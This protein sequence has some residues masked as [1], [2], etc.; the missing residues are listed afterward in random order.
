MDEAG[1]VVNFTPIIVT[2]YEN[3]LI[4]GEEADF[5]R[6][7][8][9]GR[10]IREPVVFDS[11]VDAI[12]QATMSSELIFDTMRRLGRNLPALP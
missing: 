2:K 4:N 1:Q 6:H 9:R 11:K 3:E 10:S 12:S 5:L 7:R 8:V